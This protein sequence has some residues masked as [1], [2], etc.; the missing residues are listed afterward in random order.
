MPQYIAYHDAA[1]EGSGGVWFSLLHNMQPIVWREAFPPDIASD[2]VSLENPTGTITNSDLE[3]AAEVFA[4]GII[5]D[6]AATIKHVALGTLS[7]NTPTVGWI[8]RMA[9]KSKSAVSGRL[10]RGLSYMLFW[11]HAGRLTTVHVE[12]PENVMADIA[13]R[14]AKAQALF[15]GSAPTLSDN[16]FCSSFDLAFP[17][18]NEQVWQLAKVPAW[19]KSNVFETLRGKQ[20]DLRQWAGLQRTNIG[21]HGDSTASSTESAATG[22]RQQSNR[23]APHF[24]CCRVGR[25]A[26]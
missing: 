15:S 7:D 13:S 5:M 23:H 9:S 26:R 1:A 6:R 10:L 19:L 11:H 12:G 3:L 14:P 24:C 8:D 22:H 21:K 25:S 2:V 4:V 16:D 20:L 18:P 17:L